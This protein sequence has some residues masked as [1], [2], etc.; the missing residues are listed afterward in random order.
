M[1][2]PEVTITNYPDLCHRT[3]APVTE[4]MLARFRNQ[5]VLVE[6]LNEFRE[7]MCV[8][9]RLDLLKKHLFYGKPACSHRDAAAAPLSEDVL[10]RFQD[11]QIVRTLHAILGMA[12]ESGEIVWPLVNH[13]RNGAVLDITNLFEEQGDQF[14]YHG[15][16]CK[17]WNVPFLNT[18][19]RNIAKLFKRYPEK[20]TE[21]H[22]IHR[23][24]QAERTVLEA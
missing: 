15:L 12:T 13:I 20:F 9:D 8:C 14:W 11:P 4:E 5:E 1:S 7:L 17:I 10:Q 23:D 6:L 22:A 19:T 2:S 16:L 18:L 24:L 3:E 21:T